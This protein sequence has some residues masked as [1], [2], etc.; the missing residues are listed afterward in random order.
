MGRSKLLI[1]GRGFSIPEDAHNHLG[2][3]ILLTLGLVMVGVLAVFL[4]LLMS[5][6]F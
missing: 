4:F 5:I 3:R 1:N 6:V 2:G